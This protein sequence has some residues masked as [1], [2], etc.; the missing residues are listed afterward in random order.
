MSAAIKTNEGLHDCRDAF[1]RTLEA[2]AEVDGRV[3]VVVN[4]A[5]STRALRAGS[6]NLSPATSCPF[7]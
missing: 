7:I 1:S 4:A 6:C 2:L 3:V 5:C